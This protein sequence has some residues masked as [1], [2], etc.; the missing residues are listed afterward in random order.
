[1]QKRHE[2]TQPPPPP[3]PTGAPAAAPAAMPLLAHHERLTEAHANFVRLQEQM[4]QE[5]LA[6]RER[7]L[8]MFE[9]HGAPAPAAPELPAMHL[10]PV[11]PVQ[12]PVAAA[13]ARPAP[14]V[15]STNV[16]WEDAVLDSHVL[17]IGALVAPL[18]RAAKA[19]GL[20]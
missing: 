8:E 16:T 7:L 5:F 19:D 3:A 14:S 6:H 1:M 13:P 12:P 15:F 10:P 20:G 17:P 9:Q 18:A 11:R 2:S 4:H